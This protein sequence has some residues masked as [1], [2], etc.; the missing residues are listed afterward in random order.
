M[1]RFCSHQEICDANLCSVLLSGY[2]DHFTSFT[3][4]LDGGNNDPCASSNLGGIFW[5]SVASLI[6]AIAAVVVCAV[7][8]ELKMRV[9]VVHNQYNRKSSTLAVLEY[10]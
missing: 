3:I 7:G 6:V 4:L 8:Y 9:R 10:E 1:V 5:L 2:T